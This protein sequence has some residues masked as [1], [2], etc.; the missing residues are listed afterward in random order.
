[1]ID[2]LKDYLEISNFNERSNHLAK[3]LTLQAYTSFKHFIVGTMTRNYFMFPKIFPS[4][5]Q[6]DTLSAPDG[7][8]MLRTNS[9][10]IAGIS[11]YKLIDN[12][13]PMPSK[14]KFKK[15]L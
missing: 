14:R 15:I 3:L 7:I 11:R 13:I 6:K 12:S 8:A 4:V 9:A 10:T 5:I 2:I 1:M